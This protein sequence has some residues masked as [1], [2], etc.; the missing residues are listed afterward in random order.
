VA[1]PSVLIAT[2][3]LNP[4]IEILV[5]SHT[6]TINIEIDACYLNGLFNPDETSPV[7]KS[8][9]QNSQPLFF[10]QVVHPFL[11][12]I[13]DEILS[14]RVNA[15]FEL[16]FLRLKAEELVCRL[17]MELEKRDEKSCMI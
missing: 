7:L 14:E 16:F 1:V 9:L 3:S 12:R 4:D 15:T 10:E 17:L 6:A 8:L 11:Q 2:R 5:H 13:V